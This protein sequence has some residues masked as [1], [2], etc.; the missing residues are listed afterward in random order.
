MKARLCNAGPGQVAVAIAI[1]GLAGCA[2][3]N[4]HASV[5]PATTSKF[6]TDAEYMASVEELAN[7]RGVRV[8]WV[9]PPARRVARDD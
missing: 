6:V 9:N 5:A 1:A 7:H 4:H 8:R 2:S 3:T